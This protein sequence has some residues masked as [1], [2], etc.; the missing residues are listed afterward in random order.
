[1]IFANFKVDTEPE[2]LQK[3]FGVQWLEYCEKTGK[4]V[5]K[6]NI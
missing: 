4:Y 6:I 5:P 2:E 1:M 3:L